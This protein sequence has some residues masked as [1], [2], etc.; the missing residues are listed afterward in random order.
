MAPGS[1]DRLSALPD[2]ILQHILSFLPAQEAVRTCVLAQ[3]WRQVWKLVRRLHITGTTTPTYVGQVHGFVDRLLQARLSRIERSPL[4]MCEIKFDMFDDDDE[5][6]IHRWIGHV[7]QCNVQWLSLNIFDNEADEMPWFPLPEPLFS[8]YLTRL[9]LYGIEFSASFAHFS[10][11]PALQELKIE[12]CDLS[13]VLE[14][15]SPSLRRLS[16]D[17][18]NSCPNWRFRIFA[19]RLVWLWLDIPSAER[20]PQLESMPDLLV[21]Y[22]KLDWCLDECICEGDRMDC[23][24]VNQAAYSYAYSDIDHGDEEDSDSYA[25]D[26]AE[27]DYGYSSTEDDDNDHDEE[28]FSDDDNSS[29]ITR[30]CVVLGGLS[31]ATDLTLISGHEMFVFRRDLRCCPTFSKLRTLLINDYWCEPPDCRALACILEHSPVLERLTIV[32]SGKGP[33]YKVE[34]KGYLNAV[35]RPA[36]MISEHLRIVEVK[37]DADNDTFHNVL[38][39]LDSLNIWFPCEQEKASDEEEYTTQELSPAK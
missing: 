8:P 25:S 19:P 27:V 1:A 29:E 20:T 28:G 10:S 13:E 24:H 30:K 3:S 37:C 12:K 6:F 22:V 11:C 31:E 33:K 39:F 4:D 26:P 32:L 18:C 17:D 23:C 9:D 15:D 2:E 16:I 14:M 35:R 38:R 21:A 34:M 36:M 5:A 7:L